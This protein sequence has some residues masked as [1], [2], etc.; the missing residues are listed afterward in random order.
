[1]AMINHYG[2]DYIGVMFS[3]IKYI[4]IWRVL[5]ILSRMFNKYIPFVVGK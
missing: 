5:Y 2:S 3:V 1:M 4:G